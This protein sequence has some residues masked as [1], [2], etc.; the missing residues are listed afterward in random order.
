MKGSIAV[1]SQA[2]TKLHKEAG[3]FGRRAVVSLPEEQV[4]S[5]VIELPSMDDSEVEQSLQWQVEQFIPFLSIKLS[6]V[7]K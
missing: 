7:I 3:V 4:S 1:V 2:I 5:H 6:G